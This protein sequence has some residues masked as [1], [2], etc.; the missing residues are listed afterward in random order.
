MIPQFD[1]KKEYSLIK[2]E[3][4]AELENVF[5][6]T[7][8]IGGKNVESIEKNIAKYIGTKY[9]ISCNSG[10]DALHFALRSL[11]LKKD[12]EV[13]TTPFTFISTL[14]AIM[15]VGAKPV[16]ADIDKNSYNID[17]NEI[18]KKITK[19]TKAIIPVHLFGNPFDINGLKKEINNDSIKIIEDCAQS[20]GAGINCQRTGSIGDIGCFSFYP[21][22][23]LGCY[24]DG[25]MVTTNS[26]ET[27]NIIK[28][29]KNHG[30]SKRYYHDILGYNSRLDE[31]QAAILNIKLKYIDSNNIKRVNIAKTYNSLLKNISYINLPRTE[32]HSF[33]VYHQYTIS[34]EARD[35]IKEELEKNDITSAIYY[36]L[37]LEKQIVFKNKYSDSCAYKNSNLIANTCLSLPMFPNLTQDEVKKV[38]KVIQNI[39]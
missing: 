39:K 34:S 37:S 31:I 17:K 30:S 21:T 8:F 29:L 20:F 16:F 35:T 1:L 36:P 25:G 4:K 33:H 38:C 15:Y 27:Y 18:L 13:I 19:K 12:D 6:N 14:E 23:N 9:A 28:K 7:S 2:D 3:V 10:T 32:D 22:K 26:E 5:A 11:G 24:G